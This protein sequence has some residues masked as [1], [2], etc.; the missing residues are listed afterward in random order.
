LGVPESGYVLVTLHRPA[1]V[2]G[3]L[4]PGAL[5]ELQALSRHLPVVF[6]MHPRTRARSHGMATSGSG[7]HLIAPVGYVDFLALERS[8][9]AVLTDSGGVQEETTFL[10]VPCFTLRDNTER[11][12]TITQGTNRLLGLRIEALAR[13]P[14]LLASAPSPR[15]APLGWDGRAGERVASVLAEALGVAG[16]PSAVAAANQTVASGA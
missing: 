3:P 12:V 11:P 9:A 1:L 5:A 15:E 6:P 16:I 7:L 13:I 10:G 14:E 8:A 2:D 4:L